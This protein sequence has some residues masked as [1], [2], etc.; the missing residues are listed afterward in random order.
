M[1]REFSTGSNRNSDEGKLHFM[2]FLSPIVIKRFGEYMEKHRYLEDGTL[3][4]PDNW[5]KG[6]PKN[7]YIDSGFRHFHD[8][9]MEHEGYK[10]RDGIEDALMGLLFNVMGYSHEYLKEKYEQPNKK[11]RTQV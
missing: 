7:S 8:W 10:S 6:I 1:K 2:G 9:W 4:E 5:K 11:Q 3:R